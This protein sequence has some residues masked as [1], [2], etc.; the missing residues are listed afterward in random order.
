MTDVA[1]LHH[2]FILDA[3]L[4]RPLDNSEKEDITHALIEDLLNTLKMKKLG[5]LE[6]YPA[7][8]LRA[9]GWSFLQPITTSHIAGHYFERPGNHP[10]IHIDLYSCQ[11][12]DWKIALIPLTRHFPLGAWQAT[13][14]NRVISSDESSKDRREILDIR[15][16][17]E[18]V[19]QVH[20]VM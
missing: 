5:P 14:V 12:F 15:G 18:N 19:E 16:S 9:P 4:L 6:I 7:T 17:G 13:F 1:L 3:H 11:G 2:H 8:D 20:R 10:H